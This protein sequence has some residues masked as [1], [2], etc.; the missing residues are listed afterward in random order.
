[1]SKPNVNIQNQHSPTPI[2]PK[3][4]IRFPD[5][6]VLMVLLIALAALM[7]Y[8]VPA[9]SFDRIE[10]VS[11][12][13][14]VVKAGSYK[15]VEQSPVAVTDALMAIPTGLQQSAVIIFFIL[16]I[17]GAFGIIN[18]T[19]SLDALMGKVIFKFKGSNNDQFILAGLIVFF[20]FVSGVV[21]MFG[22]TIVFI[23][24]IMLLVISLGYDALVAVAVVMASIAA[25][26]GAAPINPFTVG[27]AQ[28]IAEL[29]LYSGMWF[30]WVFWLLTMWVLVLYVLSYGKKIKKDPSK[31][32]VSHID[33]SDLSIPSA[34]SIVSMNNKHIRVLAIF[35]IGIAALIVLIIKMG[36][37]MAHMSAYFLVMGVVSGLA[38]GLRPND[39]SRYFIQGAQQ[40]V[41]AA[42]LVGFAKGIAVV[43]TQGQILDTIVHTISTPFQYMPKMI[44]AGCM[45]LMQAVINFFVPSGTGQ[46]MLTMPIMVP[47]ADV[48]GFSRQI[49]VLA[50]QMGDGFANGIV[51]TLG[52]L[53]A[54]LGIGRIPYSVWFKFAGKLFL[55]QM[56]MSFAACMVAVMIGLT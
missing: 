30:R 41:Y 38:Y 10:S 40:M 42:L 19:Q 50:Y 20:G 11:T 23:P 39:I 53:M 14:M 54:A 49:A 51:P 7:T 27:L 37:G 6:Y 26:Y 29:P 35:F 18:G 17:G 12:G 3:K 46:A 8:I 25:G 22:E 56:A 9:G 4:Q 13:K 5:A 28:G 21:G 33:Y 44:A 16:V 15:T 55:I 45:V 24:V 1:M 2:E 47:L 43:L 36:F 48:M 52:V 34:S 31:S 32:L